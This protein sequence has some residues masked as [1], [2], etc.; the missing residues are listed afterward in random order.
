M[1]EKEMLQK[2]QKTQKERRFKHTL[3]V[4]SEAERLAPLFGV[5]EKK[6]RIAALLHDCAKNIDETS[7]QEFEKICVK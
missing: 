4:I 2:L 1:T 5:D 6:A 7:G 3:G